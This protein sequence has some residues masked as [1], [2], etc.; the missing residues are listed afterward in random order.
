[1]DIFEILSELDNKTAHIRMKAPTWKEVNR[2]DSA[3]AEQTIRVKR[4]LIT[5]D[6]AAG[7]I[8]KQLLG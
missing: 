6:E 2:L 1:M 3:I 5:I 8:S 7:L 4:R